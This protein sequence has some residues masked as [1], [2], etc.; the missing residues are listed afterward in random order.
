[1]KLK[2]MLSA[3]V[4]AALAFGLPVVTPIPAGAENTGEQGVYTLF[5]LRP[6]VH[7]LVP[8]SNGVRNVWFEGYS[9]KNPVVGAL[10]SVA[11]E[12]EGEGH[13]SLML[14]HE[15]SGMSGGTDATDWRSSPLVINNGEYAW[16]GLSLDETKLLYVDIRDYVSV[17]KVKLIKDG[18]VIITYDIQNEIDKYKWSRSSTDKITVN[19]GKLQLCGVTAANIKDVYFKVT[20]GKGQDFSASLNEFVVTV[21]SSGGGNVYDKDTD[22]TYTQDEIANRCA[23]Y[24]LNNITDLEASQLVNYGFEV[25]PF[26]GN[27]MKIEM[28]VPGVKHEHIMNNAWNRDSFTHYKVCKTG[29]GE[30]MERGYHDFVKKTLIKEPTCIAEG[31]QEEACSVCGYT[32]TVKLPMKYHTF[33]SNEYK[34]LNGDCHWQECSVCHSPVDEKLNEYTY[35]YPDKY[36]PKNKKNFEP[37]SLN[38]GIALV[39]PTNSTKGITK[40]SC[41]T[42]SYAKYEEVDISGGTAAHEHYAEEWS[43]DENSHWY[44]CVIDGTEFEKAAHDFDGGVIDPAS[45]GVKKCT[46]QTCGYV[47]KIPCSDLNTDDK[48]DDADVQVLKIVLEGGSVT[49]KKYDLNDDGNVDNWDLSELRRL[50]K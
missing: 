17:D 26:Y 4:S 38:D 10:S 27:V 46:C 12:V 19:K 34:Y 33:D 40:F 43:T 25:K 45:P 16:S 20:Y 15:R 5:E 39:T 31:E 41:Y 6:E 35:R 11:V 2:K 32:R 30:V 37:H 21:L 44:K 1:M 8:D 9:S 7:V 47:K 36:Y 28:I 49:D 18:E 13:G 29:C 50:A 3:V 23:I 42:C 24:S 22:K 14:R 48:T